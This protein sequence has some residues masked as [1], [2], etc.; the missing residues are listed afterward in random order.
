MK[1]VAFGVVIAVLGCT[2]VYAQPPTRW[3]AAATASADRVSADAV[4]GGGVSAVGALFGVR[5]TPAFSI[6]VEANQGLGELS[7][8]YVGK[9][10]SFAPVG[11]SQEE[12]ERLAITMQTRNTWKPGFGWSVLAMWQTTDSARAGFGVFGGFTVTRYDE[13]TTQTVLNIPAGVNVTEPDVH[14]IIPDEQRARTRGGLTGGVL[15]PI[16]VAR[17]VTVAPEV[18]YTYGSFGDETYTTVRGGVRLMWGS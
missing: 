2:S 4:K 17:Q 6:E 12:I 11:A 14:R 18:R 15:I 5:L 16:R 13:R 1:K 8:A 9:A 7:R 3:Y 10:V